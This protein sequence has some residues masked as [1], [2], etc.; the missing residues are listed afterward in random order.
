[1]WIDKM[2]EH[3]RRAQA[4]G[5]LKS[6]IDTR[7]VAHFIVMAHEGFYGLIKGLGSPGIYQVLSRSMGLYFQTISAN[8]NQSKR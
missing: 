2:D 4:Q 5:F 1:M 6:D 8:G 3:L 7:E